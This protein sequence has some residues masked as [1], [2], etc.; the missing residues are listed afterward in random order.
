MIKIN[1]NGEGILAQDLP[2]IFERFY[3]GIN[4]HNDSIGIG[5]AMSKIIFQKQGGTIEVKSEKDNGA[6]FIIKIYK[7]IV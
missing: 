3:K 4:A 6:E 5:L 1:D 7:S 2:H